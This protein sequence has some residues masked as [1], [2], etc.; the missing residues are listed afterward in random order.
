MTQQTKAT[1]NTITPLL[2]AAIAMYISYKSS[3]DFTRMF[4]FGAIA[5]V[6]VWL[7]TAR[8][9]KTIYN[10]GPAYVPTG[11]GEGCDTYDPVPL[12][13]ELYN[14]ISG[15]F[16]FRNNAVYDKL[17]SLSPCQLRKVYNTWND[18]YYA[19]NNETLPVAISGEGFTWTSFNGQFTN[20]QK[21]RVL[22]MFRVNGLQ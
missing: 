8:V 2:A 21:P 19:E 15:I 5:F 20:D 9:T 6:L 10:Q 11:T 14:D 18:K 4:I 12:T 13:A 7:V 3:K 17:L 22:E 16:G 1:I